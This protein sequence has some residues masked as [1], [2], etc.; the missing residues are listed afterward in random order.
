[1]QRLHLARCLRCEAVVTA[2]PDSQH[3]WGLVLD[4]SELTAIAIDRDA[5]TI[6]VG[7]GAL[8][9]DLDG[10]TVPEGYV[11]PAGVISHTGLAGLTLRG[12]HGVGQQE[13]RPNHRQLVRR[14]DRDRCW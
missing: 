12:R 9:R 1:M 5:C 7:G 3:A 4:L 13:I 6:E 2:F 8:L 10:A 14:R 11:V